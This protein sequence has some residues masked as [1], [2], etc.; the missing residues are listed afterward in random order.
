LKTRP[1]QDQIALVNLGEGA[2]VFP[3][4][5]QL[6]HELDL[7][8]GIAQAR[9]SREEILFEVLIRVLQ[10]RRIINRDGDSHCHSSS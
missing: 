6:L 4:R 1:I 8:E 5:E 7:L 2:S 3:L 10:I 9:A